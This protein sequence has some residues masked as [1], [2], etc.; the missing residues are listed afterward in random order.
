MTLDVRVTL[1]GGLGNQMFQF[2]FAHTLAERLDVPLRVDVSVLESERDGVTRRPYAL[3]IFPALANILPEFLP[4]GE[5]GEYRIGD[6]IGEA[7]ELYDRLEREL[8]GAV[9]DRPI[10]VR[11]F[12]QKY[13][14]MTDEAIAPY[15]SLLTSREEEHE[16]FGF[17]AVSLASSLAVHVRRGDYVALAA[18]RRF[19]GVLG[20]RYLKAALRRLESDYH[21]VIVFSDDP[22]WCARSLRFRAP[23]RIVPEDLSGCHGEGH[24]ALMARVDSLVIANSSFSWWG[25][26]LSELHRASVE[27][28]APGH[29]IWFRGRPGKATGL[30]PRHWRHVEVDEMPS[31]L[32]TFLTRK[33]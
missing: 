16:A 13:G 2:A 7:P 8:P 10:R 17:D 22:D 12:F 31:A 6:E 4:D 5:E 27:V 33:L 3:G 15:A 24:L 1:D 28:V 14:L 20:R 26:R 32:C 9:G 23:H 19:H 18:A 29:S 30:L 21:E 25:A 11:G